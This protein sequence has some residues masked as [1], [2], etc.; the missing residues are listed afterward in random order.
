MDPTAKKYIDLSNSTRAKIIR[1]VHKGNLLDW[2]ARLMFHFKPEDLAWLDGE[3]SEILDQLTLFLQI[4]C[5]SVEKRALVACFLDYVPDWC[6]VMQHISMIQCTAA[7]AAPI[8]RGHYRQM[9]YAWAKV[10][11]ILGL[12]EVILDYCQVPCHNPRCQYAYMYVGARFQ[13]SKWN[14][15]PYCNRY[16]QSM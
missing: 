14:N 3:S 10:A 11:T 12:T 4:L 15:L 7:S 13:C 1:T 9:Q 2:V 8:M 6:K 16:C 5:S